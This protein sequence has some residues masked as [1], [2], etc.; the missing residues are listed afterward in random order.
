MRVKRPWLAYVRKRGQRYYGKGGLGGVCLGTVTAWA[1]W[2]EEQRKKGVEG[3][4]EVPLEAL[5]AFPGSSS[6]LVI[7]CKAVLPG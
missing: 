2:G 5:G 4:E 6:G 1:V 3:V 7:T